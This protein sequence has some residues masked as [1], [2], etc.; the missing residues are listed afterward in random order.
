MMNEEWRVK[1]KNG[2]KNGEKKRPRSVGDA[3]DKKRSRARGRWRMKR[4]K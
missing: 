4:E 2:M 3:T 1:M